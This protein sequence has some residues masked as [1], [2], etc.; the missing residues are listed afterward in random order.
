MPYEKR[1]EETRC[2]EDEIPFDI[3]TS[4]TWCR[5][6]EI[7]AFRIGKTPPRKDP[8]YWDNPIYPWVS[9]ADMKADSV[10]YETNEQIN[11]FAYS[12]IFSRRISYKGT[13]LMSFKLTVG[14]V[15]ILGIDAFHNEAIVSIFPYI[16]EEGIT[17]WYLFKVLPLITK[18]GNSKDAIKGTTLNSDSL[19]NL[20]IPLPPLNEQK[21]IV[22]KIEELLP[23][24]EAYRKCETELTALN[25]NFPDALKKSILQ[26]AVQ[27]KLVDQDPNDEPADIL[28]AKIRAEKEKLIKE[29]KIKR[30]K[31]ASKIIRRGNEFYEKFPDG[32]ETLLTDLPFDIPDSWTW[33]RLGEIG[34]TNIGLTY[35]PSDIS[36][37]GIPVLRS[38]NIQKGKLHL[39][40]LIRV[41]IKPK[42]SLF[43]KNQDILICVR[44]GSKAL[45]GKSAII[46]NLQEKTS[47]GAFMAIFRT[48]FYNYVK[49]FL[50]SPLFKSTLGATNTETINQITQSNLK[51]ALIPLPPLAEQK[52]IVTHINVLL[53]L[54]Q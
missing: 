30:D 50:D 35:K 15:S 36:I 27:G 6:G 5:L 47:F 45:V 43:I 28:L 14:R 42:E 52:R 11:E 20:L 16:A 13:L 8:L 24:V 38:G 49:I 46:E 32:T 23:Y 3:P 21:R 10:I 33:C 34:C 19:Y 39:N 18:W 29:G 44:N 25:K 4:W 48:P 9:I 1:G 7:V 37:K 53:S 51:N 54:I 22:E 17:K 2:I 41:S 12:N 31:N 40:N 26:W